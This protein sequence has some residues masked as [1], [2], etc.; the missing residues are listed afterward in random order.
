M[1]FQKY[2]FNF[3]FQFII[4]IIILQK[5][6]FFWKPELWLDLTVQRYK[7]AIN[8]IFTIFILFNT[9]I[10]PNFQILI[11]IIIFINSKYN[12]LWSNSKLINSPCSES[13]NIANINKSRF[14]VF[15]IN[16]LMKIFKHGPIHDVMEWSH[17][18]KFK[19]NKI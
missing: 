2:D 7:S 6:W 12:N 18:L 15:W 3:N 14:M 8:A 5:A 16:F 9:W 17:T 10:M 1:K 4:F 19:S 11:P 13:Q